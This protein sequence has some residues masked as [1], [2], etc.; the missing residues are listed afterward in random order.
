MPQALGV[1]FELDPAFPATSRALGDLALCHV[2]LQL[3]A[4]HPWI[5]LIPR[6]TGAVELQ[7]LSGADR[8]ALMQEVVQAG[9]AVR[10]IGEALGRPV[11]KLN[12]GQLGN[13][14]SQL[15]VHVVGRR[16]DDAAW[17]GPVW[18]V[19]TA[20]SY[21]DEV[22]ERAVAAARQVLAL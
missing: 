21:S 11:A 7:D 6:I 12:V 8:G 17:P 5:V 13:V 10:A 18:G 4:R 16:P 15:H 1:M 19:G 3:D 14:T 22:L 20:E 2:R 9:A